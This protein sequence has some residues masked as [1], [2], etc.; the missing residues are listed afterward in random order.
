MKRAVTRMAILICA[1]CAATVLARAASPGDA[2]AGAGTDLEAALPLDPLVTAGEL[3]N[4]LRYYIR[5]NAEPKNRAQLWLAVDAGSVLEDD[6]QQGLAHFVEHMAFNGTEHFSKNE[7][8][9][10]MES[11]GMRFGP[12]LNAYTNFDETI[13]MLEVPTDTTEIV[14]TAFQILEDWAHLL[15]FDEEEIDKERGVVGEEWRLG[16]GAQARMLDK[17][18]PV[19]FKNS[20]YAQRLTIGKKAVIDTCHYDTLRRFYRDWYR[21]DLMA[22]VAV[23]DFD[24]AWISGLVA[25]H[26]SRIR[27]SEAPR[28]RKIY[29]VPDHQETLTS[30]A[31]DPEAAY[32]TAAIIFKS[33]PATDVTIADYRRRLVERIHDDMLSDR[34]T[35]LT[36][37][38][39]PPFLF[40]MSADVPLARSKRLQMIAALVNQDG[41]ERGLET[42][43]YETA[44]A[45]Q[46]GF[47]P[48]ELE[49]SKQELIRD[50]ESAYAERDK[51]ESK[52]L[53]IECLNH[54]LRGTALPGMEAEYEMTAEL[55]PGITLEEVNGLAA[56]RVAE[57]NRVVLVNA[58]EKEGVAV[59]KEDQLEE[60][61][62]RVKNTDVEPYVDVASDKPLVASE[63]QPVEIVRE[64]TRD[65][66]G[67]TEWTLS[68]GV[69]VVLKPTDFKNDEIVFYGYSTGGNSLASDAAF[70][71][72]Q[73]ATDLVTESGVGEFTS[74]ELEKMLSGKVVEVTPFIDTMT[75]GISGSASP[76]DMDA[77]FK[78]IYLYATSPRRDQ[79]SFESLKAKMQ[80]F[81]ENRSASPEAAFID[82]IQVTLAQ[83]NL[84]SRPWSMD[85]VGEMDMAAAYDFYSDRFAD[86]DDFTFYI[87]GNFTT[88]GIR[89]LVASY[90]GALPATDR[91][92]TW[93]DPGVTPPRGVVKK[94]VRKGIEEKAQ[95]GIVF[96]G[97]FAWS[98][99]NEHALKSLASVMEIDLRE[100]LREDLGGT[101]G[102]GISAEAHPY[103][104]PEYG[105]WITFGCDPHRVDELTRT[106]FDKIEGLR[107]QGPEGDYVDRVKE[108]Q[109]R[110]YEVNL[111][112][113][114]FWLR[115]LR[116]SGFEGTDP[117]LI[118][119]YPELVRRLSVDLMRE[120]AATYLDT[121][122]YV[123]VVLLP[124][125]E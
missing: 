77:M 84:R 18:L 13:Y 75:E 98:P 78:L 65:E 37:K 30:V 95:V 43:L 28:E 25:D 63:P 112:N 36:K 125:N 97:P 92:E 85:L 9:H 54:F 16:R 68:N 120:T 46:Y 45:N 113:N 66:L 58:P 49:R 20:R 47:T 59:P 81:V 89:P 82:T 88:E 26:F 109:S 21:P 80:G 99:E 67:L 22:V 27:V 39:D 123:Q 115:E 40:A 50:V 101:Y 119:R 4:G 57:T 107:T 108:A 70:V 79:E 7:L 117:S 100:V 60:V 72:A 121:A 55:V 8:I 122:N 90:L 35:E 104:K 71:S 48:S 83:H 94:T 32:T 6:D 29:P 114:A 56:D 17:Q 10:Y 118:L 5:A 3:D 74:I 14:E 111:R 105:L 38:A 19:L 51:T 116:T 41:I 69:R 42:L 52:I 61:Y 93:R 1:L 24:P 103:P 106:V 62:E 102:V 64:S 76:Q 11:I 44:R 12:E 23:G 86:A 87:V 34:L 91:V 2:P 96:T 110:G 31:T 124:E 33:A 15:S 73:T 53:A